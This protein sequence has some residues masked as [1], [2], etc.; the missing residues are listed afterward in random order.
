MGVVSTVDNVGPLLQRG[1]RSRPGLSRATVMNAGTGFYSLYQYLLRARQLLPRYRPQVLVVVVF[2]GNDF[3]DL[4]DQRRPHLTDDFVE[5]PISS[6]PP[7]ETT[8]ARQRRL[9]LPAEASRAF[10]QGLNQAAYLFEHPDRRQ[11]ILRKADHTLQALVQLCRAQETRLLV[12]LL[13][14][15]DLVFP[16]QA[17]LAGDRVVEVVAS[18]VQRDLHRDFLGLLERHGVDHVDLL[19]IFQGVGK[20]DLYA[21]DFHIWKRGHATLAE[22]VLPRL[23][24]LL[25][26]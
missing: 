3:L 5:S 23:L 13:P 15:F 4:E 12:A 2:L 21:H 10:W 6:D 14:S 18:G 25:S 1:L 24:D 17:S 20:V 8:S 7:A 19:P 22:A 16:E 26:R 9:D 11:P